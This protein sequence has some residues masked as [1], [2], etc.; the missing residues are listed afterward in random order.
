MLISILDLEKAQI[1]DIMVPRNEVTLI[2]L[3]DPLDEIIEQI[4]EVH[5]S[6]VPTG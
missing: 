3:K 2:D 5:Y 1:E 4:Q 6:L